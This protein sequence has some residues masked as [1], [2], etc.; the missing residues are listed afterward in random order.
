MT[1]RN[2]L[3]TQ[4]AQVLFAGMGRSWAL[5]VL[6]SLL[7]RLKRLQWA[8]KVVVV[9][10]ASSSASRPE[11]RIQTWRQKAKQRLAACGLAKKES[12][13]ASPTTQTNPKTCTQASKRRGKAQIVIAQT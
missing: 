13:F 2:R 7:E 12:N 10:A 3:E 1:G 5:S 9:V 8:V 4:A 11:A 6:P